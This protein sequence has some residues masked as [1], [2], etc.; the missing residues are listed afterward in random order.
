MDNF[1]LRTK[2]GLNFPQSLPKGFYWIRCYTARQLETKDGVFLQPVYVL[3]KQ[4]HDEGTY[5]KKYEKSS[6]NN[7]QS[8]SL[9]FFPERL[10]AIPGIIS[11]GVIEI[12]DG[13]NNPL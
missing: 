12:R 7:K 1:S 9:Q 8:A 2:R 4:L 13:Y 3:N 11:T 5:A 10:T 6:G